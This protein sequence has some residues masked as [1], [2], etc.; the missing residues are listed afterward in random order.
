MHFEMAFLNPPSAP[1]FQRGER[2]DFCKCLAQK[3]VVEKYGGSFKK[4]K[5]L[6][7]IG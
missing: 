6:F 1:L 5:V 2:G 4:N 3:E 7:C